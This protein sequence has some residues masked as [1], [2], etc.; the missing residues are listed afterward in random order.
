ML[1]GF[2]LLSLPS[3]CISLLVS[4]KTSDIHSGHLRHDYRIKYAYFDKMLWK[5]SAVK[6][7]DVPKFLLPLSVKTMLNILAHASYWLAI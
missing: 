1:E 7:Q 4:E 5:K 3:F 6:S 2:F